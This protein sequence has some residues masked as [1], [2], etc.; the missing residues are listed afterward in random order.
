M[1]TSKSL[2][3]IITVVEIVT[4]SLFL[5]SGQ[6]IFAVMSTVI[7][8]GGGTIPMEIDQATGMAKLTFSVAPNNSGYLFAKLNIGFGISS[9]DGSYSV[10]NMTTTNL[11][12]GMKKNITL[13]LKV[14][15]DELQRYTKGNGTFDVYMSIKTLYDLA[16]MDYNMKAQG[17]T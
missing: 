13:T 15:V 14:P 11:D 1:K 8:S 6:T 16:G 5:L 12:P 9:A 7:S 10:R 3:W 4:I 17:G 2:G